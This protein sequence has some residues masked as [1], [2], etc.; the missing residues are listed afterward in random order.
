M[1]LFPNNFSYCISKFKT[2]KKFLS[3][4]PLLFMLW[5]CQSGKSETTVSKKQVI[6]TAPVPTLPDAEKK[7]Y[8]DLVENFLESSL[9]RGRFN[10][11]ILVAKE[12][13]PVYEAY[14]G[15]KNIKT[16]DTLT[17][18]TS[19]Q[20][21]STSKP[22]TAAAALRLVQEGKLK[23]NDPMS[24]FF[25]GFPYADITVRTLLNHRSGLPNYLYYMEDGGWNRKLL[26]TNSDVLSTLMNWQPP[27]AYRPNSNFNYCNTNYVLLAL[28][29]EKISGIPFPEYMKRTFFD[30]L[31]MHNTYVHTINDSAKLTPSYDGY[32]GEWQVDFSDGPY[33]D[34]NVYSTPRDL[35]KW[36][37]AWYNGAVVNQQWK[38]SAFLPYSN[39][40]PSTHNYGLGWRLLNMPNGKKVIYH[41]GRWHGFNSAFARLPDEKITI[42]VLGNKFNR[43]VYFASR[44]MYNLFGN[45]DGKDEGEE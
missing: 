8:H 44:K 20:I 31:Q 19:L 25:P 13:V 41:N 27:K 15:Y 36:D 23:L 12:G 14:L 45:Y 39:E 2:L 37:Q 29:V 22:F 30:P 42:I 18:E 3:L 11:S 24:L 1:T 34:K 21:A 43:N 5:S 10:G 9:L 35:L 40:R 28:I 4:C 26:A 17:A 16:K 38:D 33:G 6:A 32:G 7:K